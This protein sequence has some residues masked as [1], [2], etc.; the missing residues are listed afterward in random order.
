MT[1]PQVAV[2]GFGINSALGIG[3]EANTEALQAG[4][5][6]IV[7]IREQWEPFGFR[8]LVAGNI[9]VAGL[10]DRFD[11]KQL[12]FMCEPALLA[13]AAT[14][15]AI[16]HAGLTDDLVQSRETGVIL[17]TG[18]GASI[19]DVL[20]LCDR[21][22]ERGAAK[23]GAYHTPIIMGSSV[24]AN[25]GSVFHIHGHSYSITSACATSAHAIMMG[26]DVIRS[27]R[28]KRMIVG[29]SEDIAMYAAGSF[30]GMNALSSAFNDRPTAASRPLDAAR[31][32]F[33]YSGGAGILILE[34]LETALARGAT[35]HGII[36]GAE[37]TC[38]GNEMVAPSGFGAEHSMNG[39]IADAGIDKREIDY[40]NLHGT[41]TPIGDI[42]EVEAVKRVFGANV[43]PFSST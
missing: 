35:I 18:A 14:A 13:A 11:R 21:L 22:R 12:R 9:R 5:S 27:G 8:S 33:V 16:A 37:A 20:F 25:V 24:T 41:S 19:T 3:A 4:R 6:G 17:G 43:P 15:D 29:G 39:A 7:S 42:I 30:E 34:E 28:Q 10:A 31:D 26:M 38:D 36:A 32:G 1:R 40:L 2:T 23:V